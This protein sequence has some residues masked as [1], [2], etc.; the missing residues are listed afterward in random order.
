MFWP[1]PDSLDRLREARGFDP[2]EE[3]QEDFLWQGVRHQLSGLSLEEWMSAIGNMGTEQLDLLRQVL[4]ENKADAASA[5][6]RTKFTHIRGR[7]GA[8]WA[9]RGRPV[10]ISGPMHMLALLAHNR[11][12]RPFGPDLWARQLSRMLGVSDKTIKRWEERI[13]EAGPPPTD[14]SEW[15]DYFRNIVKPPRE[16]RPP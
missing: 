11:A 13:L 14:N 9:I 6:G 5:A 16:R 12:R 10:E 7:L 2:A 4:D 8:I 1:E 15:L 3:E